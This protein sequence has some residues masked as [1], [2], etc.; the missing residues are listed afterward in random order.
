MGVNPPLTDVDAAELDHSMQD[1]FGALMAV[2]DLVKGVH[3]AV[4]KL[5]LLDSTYFFYSSVRALL[6]CLTCTPRLRA[7]LPRL[8]NPSRALRI[9]VTCLHPAFCLSLAFA[10]VSLVPVCHR[11]PC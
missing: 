4:E 8:A 6:R 9:T 11:H 10:A 2:D 7:R 5:G 1:R 3:D